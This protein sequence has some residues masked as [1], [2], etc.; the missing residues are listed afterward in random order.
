MYVVEI[1]YRRK[2]SDFLVGDRAWRRIV[3]ID[4]M[5]VALADMPTFVSRI[6]REGVPA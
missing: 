4:L 2:S 6:L 5:L 3:S 1:S